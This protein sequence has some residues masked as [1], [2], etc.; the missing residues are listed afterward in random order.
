MQKKEFKQTICRR[1]V[2]VVSRVENNSKVTR[3]TIDNGSSVVNAVVDNLKLIH[4]PWI[5]YTLQ[6]SI[7]PLD[8]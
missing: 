5:S 8:H 3:A 4:M 2:N 1:A 6:L 7:N